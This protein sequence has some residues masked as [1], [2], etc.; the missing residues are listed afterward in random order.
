MT[1]QVA[2][3]NQKAVALATDSA[4]SSTSG[5]IYTTANKLFTLSKVEP[6][7]VMIYNNADFMGVPLETIIKSYRQQ[8]KCA[9]FD[10]L[11]KYADDF[12]S[13]LEDKNSFLFGTRNRTR[14]WYRYFVQIALPLFDSLND[15]F[16]QHYISKII[17]K[18]MSKGGSA[19]VSPGQTLRYFLD[20]KIDAEAALPDVTSIT[21]AELDALCQPFKKTLAKI[22]R[23][24]FSFNLT[25]ASIKKLIRLV[26]L[27]ATKRWCAYT[28]VVFAGFGR[29]EAFPHLTARRIDVLVDDPSG[30]NGQFKLKWRQDQRAEGVE[31]DIIPFAQGTEVM[32]YITGIDDAFKTLLSSYWNEFLDEY[33][34]VLR[35]YFPS[36]AA[37]ALRDLFKSYI[38]RLMEEIGQME[39]EVSEPISNNLFSLP[40]DELGEFAES[41]VSL[42]SLKRRVSTQKESV[43]GPIDVAVISKGD[44]F[45]WV[46][47]KHYFEKEYNPGFTRNYFRDIDV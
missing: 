20:R 18:R 36:E 7:G 1:A 44:G 29:D 22:A 40:K 30:N 41:L 9:S 12:W 24:S 6:V 21:E 10:T 4:V 38:G 5:K 11:E 23:D 15:A 25:D 16:R 45:V 3:L 43:G 31:P 26:V 46:K 42:V 2:V 37:T 34:K 33:P 39:E 28:G 19:S 47:R 32:S 13:Y 27:R 35:N 14:G 8:L 17:E